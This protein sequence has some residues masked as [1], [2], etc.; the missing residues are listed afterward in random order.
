M[1]K[2][3]SIIDKSSNYLL[4]II[5][6][7][8]FKK[9]R[10]FYGDSFCLSLLKREYKLTAEVKTALLNRYNSL[11]K[12][13]PEF[14]FEF[15]NYALIDSFCEDDEIRNEIFP[16]K[17]K[18]TPCTNWTLLRNCTKLMIDKND[19]KAFLEV[20]NKI[21]YT[22]KKSGFILDDPG[23]KS[24]Q[25]HCFSAAMIG[26]IYKSTKDDYF[27][28]SFDKAVSFIRHFILQNGKALHIGRG[29]EQTFGYGALVYILALSYEFHRDNSCLADIKKILGL[30]ESEQRSDGS[31]PLVIGS[32]EPH[33]AYLVSMNDEKYS[34]WYPYNN[35]FDYLPFM[36]FFLSKSKEILKKVKVEK[37]EGSILKEVSYSDEDFLKIVKDNYI[38]IISRPGGYWTNDQIVPLIYS[39]GNCLTPVCGGEQFQNSLY[40]EK[41]LGLP[42][43]SIS[44]LSLRYRCKSFFYKNTLIVMA[45]LGLFIRRYKFNSNSIEMI[46]KTFSLLPFKNSI[47]KLNSKSDKIRFRFSR[48]LYSE[49]EAFSA[50]GKLKL[51]IVP[52]WVKTIMELK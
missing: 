44:K 33:P 47:A 39:Q 45:P 49:E 10:S 7:G 6:S 12:S 21:K 26:D 17:F 48:N 16:L 1:K 23:V 14:H 32:Q 22:Q 8:D 31:L 29:Q 50:S 18:N 34:G 36:T 19:E 13:D 28:K 37:I 2:I 41:S 27:L 40:E 9:F 42:F 24:F 43:M 15:N 38:A 25:Y 46:D 3:E 35:F 4:S 51:S 30:L 11:D 5:K 52:S 20:K